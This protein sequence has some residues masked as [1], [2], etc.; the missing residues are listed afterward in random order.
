[1]A[2]LSLKFEFYCVLPFISDVDVVFH[3]FNVD[4]IDF[5]LGYFSS[6]VIGND[7][8][9][10]VDVK[11][12]P[13]QFLHIEFNEYVIYFIEMMLDECLLDVN[14]AL[15]LRFHFLEMGFCVIP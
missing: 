3:E 4:F 12:A 2:I 9:L 14:A 5:I 8:P 7:D 15:F 1:M 11:E 13:L 6:G 10:Y